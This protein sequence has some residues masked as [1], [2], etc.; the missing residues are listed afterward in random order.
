MDARVIKQLSRLCRQQAEG[1]SANINQFN[2][3]VV[4]LH[5]TYIINRTGLAGAVLQTPSSLIHSVSQ[6]FPPNSPGSII[7]WGECKHSGRTIRS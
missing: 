5:L 2:Q 4:H 1:M 3:Q 7:I 6:D